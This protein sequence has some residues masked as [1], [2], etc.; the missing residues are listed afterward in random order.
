MNT[1][2]KE[3]YA[4]TKGDSA[5]SQKLRCALEEKE[6]GEERKK[7]SD[8]EEHQLSVGKSYRS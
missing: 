7:G 3:G 5:M 4:L 1:W 2:I 6:W 8:P